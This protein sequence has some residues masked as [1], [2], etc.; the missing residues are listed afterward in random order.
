MT[1]NE[2]DYKVITRLKQP[3]PWMLTMFDIFIEIVK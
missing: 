3:K 1:L 2:K